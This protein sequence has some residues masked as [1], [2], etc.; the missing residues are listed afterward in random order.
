MCGKCGGCSGCQGSRVGG[1]TLA[2]ASGLTRGKL[3]KRVTRLDESLRAI[4][5]DDSEWRSWVAGYRHGPATPA[6]LTM[7]AE[8]LAQHAERLGGALT[9]RVRVAGATSVGAIADDD[10]PEGVREAERALGGLVNTIAPALGPYGGIIK[11]VHDARLGAMYGD[12]EWLGS[13][14]PRGSQGS[15]GAAGRPYPGRVVVGPAKGGKASSR[16][17]KAS[18]R[19]T[20][21]RA[22]SSRRSRRRQASTLDRLYERE[23]R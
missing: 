13:Q 5:A 12:A 15:R 11:G 2:S 6:R 3:D 10:V 18:S 20:D 14:G 8:S 21:T 16:G 17:G 19:G 9:G 4:G 22:P 7:A 1:V 23:G